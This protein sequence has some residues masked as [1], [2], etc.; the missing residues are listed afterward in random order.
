MQLKLHP[1]LMFVHAK[2]LVPV[3]TYR[4]AMKQI[5]KKWSEGHDQSTV[6][7]GLVPI[8]SLLQESLL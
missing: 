5:L 8:P 3:S 2:H 4:P 7:N 1:A 6:A